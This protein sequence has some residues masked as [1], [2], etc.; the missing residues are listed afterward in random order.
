MS[1]KLDKIYQ[2]SKRLTIDNSS[3]L[4]IMSD[5]HRGS[6][7]N[8]DN[9][10]KNQNI[11]KAALNY[12]YKRGFT[13]IELGDGD[14]LWEV[15]N[16]NSIIEVHLDTFK[17]IKKFYDDDKLI[18]VYG[19]H[20]LSKKKN[21]I[22]EKY[23]YKY[24][25]KDKKK[26]ESLLNGLVVYES[27]ILE[28]DNH[29]I[30]L[31]HGHQVDFLNGTIWWF[32]KFLVRYMWRIFEF[33]GVSDPTDS[34]KNNEIIRR[35]EKKLENWSIKNKKMLIAGHT[36]RAIFPKIGHSLYFNDGSCIHPNGITCLE[37]EIGQI[38]LINWVFEVNDEGAIYVKRKVLEGSEKI[39]KF[40][41]QYCI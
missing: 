3:K 31:V 34:A 8:Y 5:C 16:F 7:D 10:L 18:M 12:Y 1:K 27:F 24:Y 29:D 17:Q 13:Y 14:D 20:D 22:L 25:D 36:H 6:G 30:F 37:I 19:N 15:K 41:K 38:A 39:L 40:F 9:F 21:A 33:I 4:V 26:E 11:F 35:V 32:A 2:K 23:F 28:Y